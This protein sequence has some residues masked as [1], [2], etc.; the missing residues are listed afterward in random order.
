MSTGSVGRLT[1]AQKRAL[2]WLP[3]DGSWRPDPGRLTA[4]LNS[5]S[6]AW[7]GCVTAEWAASGKR[8]GMKHRWRLT[9]A[10]VEK[11]RLQ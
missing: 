7:P 5:L 3:K 8:G 2:D 10:G 6:F 1:D 4:A 11:A 9:D